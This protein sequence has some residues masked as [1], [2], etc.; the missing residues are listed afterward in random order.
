M[1]ES[2]VTQREGS[3][4]L[5]RSETECL[6]VRP[7]KTEKDVHYVMVKLERAHGEYLGTRSR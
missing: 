4:D 7:R 5:D 1:N 3:T 6:R 2:P